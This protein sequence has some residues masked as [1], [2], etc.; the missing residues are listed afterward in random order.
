MDPSSNL[1]FI[2]LMYFILIKKGII[3]VFTV[4]FL[5]LRGREWKK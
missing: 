1:A 3:K 2:R 4:L 5:I